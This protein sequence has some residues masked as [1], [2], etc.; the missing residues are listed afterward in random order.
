MKSINLFKK[1]FLILFVSLFLSCSY[2]PSVYYAKKEFSNNIYV[3][4][5][6][7]LEDPKNSVLIK[8]AMNKLIISRLDSKLV[9]RKIEADKVVYIKLSKVSISEIQYDEKG[10][11]KLY[12]ASVNIL[13]KVISLKEVKSFNVS[14]IYDFSLDDKSI[15]NDSKRFDAIKNASNKALEQVLSKLSILSFKK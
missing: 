4:L 3:D 7:N 8:D 1:V 12:R 13:V 6:I 14:G 9:K 15:I 11:T 2:K 10:F 5:D